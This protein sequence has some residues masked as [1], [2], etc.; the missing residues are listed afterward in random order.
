MHGTELSLNDYKEKLKEL[1]LGNLEAAASL[2]ELQT[3]FEAS[4]EIIINGQ[5][6]DTGISYKDFADNLLRL[7]EAYDNCAKEV[8][9]YRRAL[10]NGDSIDEAEDALEASVL[11]AEAAEKYDFQAK[12]LE[13]QSRQL[14]KTYG[15]T[16][17]AA[18]KLAVQN[19]RM[20]KGIVTLAENWEDWNK[21]LSGSERDTIDFAEAVI[22]CTA[23]VADL[24]GASSD[25][26]LPDDFFDA[27]N[28]ALLEA[29]I[30]GDITAINKLGIAV[31]QEQV[32]LLEFN[33]AFAALAEESLSTATTAFADVLN[34]EQFSEDFKTVYD[35]LEAL[36]NGTLDTAT[37][38]DEGW[39][40]ALN[41]MA[42]A[43]GMSVD[44]MNE[45][46]GS[47]GV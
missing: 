4:S 36:R 16:A 43:T 1:A 10:A 28:L 9:D 21:V 34:E 31:A 15:L 41:R 40:A 39:V 33:D 37:E 35:A 38:M 45:L 30:N 27:E 3:A 18:A 20:N 8:E 7:G 5:V 2:A 25:L 47:M 32:K 44:N 17:A 46:L 26:E 23:A 22:D 19:Q 29:A 12:E 11:L 13:V 42:L 24:V 14:A 6:I